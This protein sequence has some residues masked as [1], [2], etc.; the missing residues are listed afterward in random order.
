MK[1]LKKREKSYFI[2]YFLQT[3]L[4]QFP[5]EYDEEIL[6]EITGQIIRT[7]SIEECDLLI[8]AGSIHKKSQNH[9]EQLV[10][11][12]LSPR[13]VILI[14]TPS[15]LQF[16]LNPSHFIKVSEILD[17]DYVISSYVPSKNDYLNALSSLRMKALVHE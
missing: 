17:V 7:Y 2:P 9:F 11:K 12:M 10:Q 5:P 6:S 15:M 16:D 4:L 8:V 1:F 14:D 3:E 13:Y